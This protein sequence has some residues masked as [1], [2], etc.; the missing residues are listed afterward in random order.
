MIKLHKN[1]YQLPNL[2][3]L[4]KQVVEGTLVG[5]H[6]SPFHG[7]SAEFMEHKIYVP[8]ESTKFV[9]WK[10][11]GKTDKLYTKK[12]EDETN[13]RAHFIIDNSSS[14]HYPVR[15]GFDIDNLNKI[16]F[17]VLATAGL[18][19]ILKRQR[20]AIGLSI[21]ADTY[22]FYAKE[23]NNPKHHR[24]LLHRLEQV[25]NDTGQQKTTE[26]YRYLH[27]IAENIHRRSLIVLFTDLWEVR[28]NKTELFEALRHLK[29]NKHQVILFHVFDYKTEYSFDFPNK[30][31]KFVDIEHGTHLNIYPEQIKDT[32]NQAVA[33]YFK[34]IKESCYKYQIDYIPV[35]IALGFKPVLVPFLVAS[36]K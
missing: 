16:Q 18:M 19:E 34:Q 33:G 31:T 12:F 25:L 32:Y 5:L 28:Q 21:Y 8:G 3:L 35:D 29:Y 13:L 15:N 9:D 24:M 4:A 7:Y 27:E 30:A 23:K 26:T 6:K 10:L 20:D 17:S 2:E 14:M 1:D 22:E 11:F 36:G